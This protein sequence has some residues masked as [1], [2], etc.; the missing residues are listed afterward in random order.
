[1]AAIAVRTP[2]PSDKEAKVM[3]TGRDGAVAVV[4]GAAAGI[5]QGIALRLAEEGAA[6][7]VLDI[8]S[9]DETVSSIEREGG[10]S[11]AV[12]CDVADIESVKE[13]SEAVSSSLGLST[14]LVNAAGIYPNQPFADLTFSEWRRVLTVNLD[15]LFLVCQAFVPHMVDAGSGRIVNISSAAVGTTMSGTVPY[16]ASKMGVIGFTRALANELGDKNITV[17]AVAPGLVATDTTRS[18]FDGTPVFELASEEQIIK[19]PGEPEDIA[20]VVSFLASDDASFIT[21][22]TIVVDGGRVRV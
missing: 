10:R 13:A 18:M 21:G 20:G 11:V 9:A 5:G 22:Q 4:T 1:M 17:N 14:I 7:G 12:R 8:G 3:H 16:M 19:R 15:S 2:S 6:V